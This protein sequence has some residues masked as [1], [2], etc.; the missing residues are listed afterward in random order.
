MDHESFLTILDSRR[1]TRSLPLPVLTVSKN[2]FRFQPNGF[3]RQIRTNFLEVNASAVEF[4]DE[5][6]EGKSLT[7]RCVIMRDLS[8]RSAKIRRRDSDGCCS[9]IMLAQALNPANLSCTYKG[10]IK[11]SRMPNVLGK[12]SDPA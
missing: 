7:R 5:E 12:H 9:L 2:D 10:C 6:R 1:L 4:A 8:R 3:A 11:P